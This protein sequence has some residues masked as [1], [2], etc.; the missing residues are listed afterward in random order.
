M[1]PLRRENLGWG[2]GVTSTPTPSSLWSP[3]SEAPHHLAMQLASIADD[4]ELRLLLPQFAEPL[5][6]IVY[7]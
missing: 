7:R 1:T 6:M 5:W 2:C 4:L 3:S